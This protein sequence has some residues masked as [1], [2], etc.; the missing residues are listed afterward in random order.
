VKTG[1]CTG[2]VPKIGKVNWRD[3]P[4]DSNS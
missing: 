3:R 1:R 4:S 2:S